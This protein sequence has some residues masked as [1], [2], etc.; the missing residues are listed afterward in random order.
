MEMELREIG[1]LEASLSQPANAGY[2]CS[3][4]GSG[5][6]A[7]FFSLVYAWPWMEGRCHA[8]RDRWLRHCLHNRK[9][10]A[11]SGPTSSAAASCCGVG[12]DADAIAE[13]LH[14]RIGAHLGVVTTSGV[15]TSSSISL[16]SPLPSAA[17]IGS[18][19]CQNLV[20]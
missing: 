17:C 11:A 8:L 2:F 7:L 14:G 6:E 13:P 19:H 9:P 15:T 18:A 16:R 10:Q 12:S 5:K 4:L 20:L 1:P 3:S